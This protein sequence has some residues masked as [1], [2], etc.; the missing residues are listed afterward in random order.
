MAYHSSNHD[1]HKSGNPVV[2]SL[3][4]RYFSVLEA[5][6]LARRPTKV[7]DVGCGE[8]FTAS[9]LRSLPMT[10]DYLGVDLNGAAVAEAR[11]QNPG[12]RFEV[13]DVR[14]LGQRAD[15]VVCLEVIEHLDDPTRGFEMLARCCDDRVIVSVPWEPWFRLGNLARGKYLDRLGNHPEHLQQ[16]TP[17][18]LRASMAAEF[19]D[20]EVV[21]SFPWV[22]ASGRPKRR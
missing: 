14:E 21:T 10:F 12:M 6:V 22:F 19:D 9:F 2:Q 1:K 15:L 20:V 13:G 16:F 3:L 17:S 4:R 18:S 5:M 11:L 8:G 7:L